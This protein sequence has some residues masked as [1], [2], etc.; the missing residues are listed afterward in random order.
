MRGG[1]SLAGI[2]AMMRVKLGLTEQE[3]LDRPWILT[4]I[5]SSDLPWYDYKGKKVITS[6]AEANKILEKYY[7]KK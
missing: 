3:I 6:K 2:L 5:E 1:Q 7:P 4:Q